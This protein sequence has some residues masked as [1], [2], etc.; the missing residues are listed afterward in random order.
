[1]FRIH[2]YVNTLAIHRWSANNPTQDTTMH[3]KDSSSF[4]AKCKNA[5]TIVN[6]L[7]FDEKIEKHNARSPEYHCKSYDYPKP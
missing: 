7:A 4:A 6:S 3:Y 1:M 5:K 2:G